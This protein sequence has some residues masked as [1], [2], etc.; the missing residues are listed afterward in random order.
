MVDRLSTAW[1][2]G[3]PMRPERTVSGTI[4]RFRPQD[5][6]DEIWR[7][8]GALVRSSVATAAPDK[9]FVADHAMTVVAQLVVWADRLGVVLEPQV[10]FHPET[11]ER[12]LV[13]GCTHLSQGSRLNYRTH[14]WKVGT[15]VLG[16][17][18][19]P[20][21]PLP[22]QRSAVNAPY[23]QEEV[24]EFLA[25]ARGLPTPH[26]RRNAEALLAVVLGTG[27]QSQELTTLVGTDVHHHGGL[28]VVHVVGKR[29]RQVRVLDEWAD[30]V[31][32]FAAESG[33][34]PFFTPDRRRITRRDIIGFIERCSGEGSALFN[35][36]RLRITWIVQHLS[37]GT[38]MLRL[39]RWSGVGAG[40]LVKY[41]N[42]A[43]LPDP[44]NGDDGD[45]GPHTG[46]A[47]PEP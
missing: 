1:D 15:A 10:V 36:Q 33:N 21:K 38:H 45:G 6:P 5:V 13:E 27:L 28:V 16:H 2:G 25:W 29:A 11:I 47:P 30:P 9:P 14:L 39:E 8:I 32:R 44:D 40:Q 46:W 35:V 42:F 43:T 37:A 7:R 24:S 22:L 20:P 34:R 19:F 12:F 26:M 4:D 31:L 18:L 23:A 3:E 41:L 17:E